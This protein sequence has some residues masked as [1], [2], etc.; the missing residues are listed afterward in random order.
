LSATEN[1]GNGFTGRPALPGVTVGGL[2]KVMLWAALASG[3]FVKIEPAPFDLLMVGVIVLFLFTKSRISFVITPLIIFLLL[4]NLGGFISFLEISSEFKATMFVVTSIYMAV[5]AIIIAIVI[6]TDAESYIPIIR[7]GWIVA[8]TIA[9]GMGIAGY[10]N[11]AGTGESM[12]VFGRAVG[13]FKDP[14]VFSTFLV[15]PAIFLIH[16][17]LI[18]KQR[19]PLVSAASLFLILAGLFLAFSR[20]AW[21]SVALAALMATSLTFALTERSGLRVRIVILAVVGILALAGAIAFLLSID[22]VRELFLDRFTLIKQ[23]DTGERGRFGSQLNSIPILLERPLGFGPTFFRRV[24]LNDPHNVYLNAF[25]AYGWL[26]GVTYPLLIISSIA[27]GWRSM[28]TR[29][30]IQHYAIAVWC[31]MV[32]TM[33]QGAQIDT[34]HWR[35]FYLLLGMNWGLY[36]ATVIY[37]REQAL[38]AYSPGFK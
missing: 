6:S 20:G 22:Q 15:A 31:P 36:A 29:T 33:V 1:L 30:R 38:A 21:F 12:S 23:Y 8:G 14:N 19:W 18:G 4:Y 2:Q 27:V 13:G 34:D 35:H 17:F 25:A 3:F 37:K 5:M 24:F 11:I 7:N 32:S 9:A 10:F 16:G 28:M 26:G